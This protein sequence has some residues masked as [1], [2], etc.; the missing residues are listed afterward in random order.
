MVSK[1]IMA[2]ALSILM[3]LADTSVEPK[4]ITNEKNNLF[5]F[6]SASCS[7]C[8]ILKHDIKQDGLLKKALSSFNIYYIS[9]DSN[10]DYTFVDAKGESQQT[11][12]I[13]LKVQYGVRATPTLI[14]FDSDW[15]T[16]LQIPGYIDKTMMTKLSEYVGKG[17]YKTKELKVYMQENNLIKG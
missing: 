7:Y 12:N 3:L 6:E 13:A 17:I 10:I 1:L 11:S 4:I 2:L 16:L 15:Q 5:I 14:F 8:E 9:I